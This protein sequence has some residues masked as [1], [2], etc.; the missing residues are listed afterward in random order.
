MKCLFL[1]GALGTSQSWDGIKTLLDQQ[2]E[3]VFYDFPNHGENTKQLT[4][5]AYESLCDDLNDFVL[6][7]QLQ[8]FNIIAYS[9]GAYIAIKAILKHQMPC[10]KLICVAMKTKWNSE[11]AEQECSNLY[12]DKLSP[13]LD[14]LKS[15]HN[16]NFE[17][18][19]PFTRNVIKS[20]GEN[21]LQPNDISVLKQE[22]YFLRGSKDKMVTAEENLDFVKASPTAKYIELQDQGHLLER[23]NPNQLL[24]VLNA[25]LID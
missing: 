20:I 12:P 17:T 23:M 7:N 14:S 4:E 5:E 25:I 6:A 9:M 8:D 24:E 10:K 19:L 2:I 15:N 3:P 18:L 13:I 21:P 1:H 22:I 16:S 11:I